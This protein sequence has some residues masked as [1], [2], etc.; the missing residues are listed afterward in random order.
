MSKYISK[1]RYPKIRKYRCKSRRQNGGSSCGLSNPV[2]LPQ[3]LNGIKSDYPNTGPSVQTTGT[4]FSS[5]S[6]QRGG[7]CG[8]GGVMMGGTKNYK[9]GICP[10]MSGLLGGRSHKKNC[11]CMYCLAKKI[12]SKSK[13]SKSMR[14]KSRRYKLKQMN[15][16][17]YNNLFGI[18]TDTKSWSPNNPGLVSN[19]LALNNYNN[20]VQLQMKALG[21]NPP[22][23]SGGTYANSFLQDAQN[24]F[25]QLQYNSGASYNALAGY[26]QPVN[27]LPY[28]DQLTHSNLAKIY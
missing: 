11:K 19:H 28:K 22:F 21:G 20:D 6:P 18:G 1:K 2:Q 26:P 25:R 10:C 27:P 17:T 4:I 23:Q 16:G 13:R 3:N 24:A 12:K 9:G 7:S 8:C 5:S 15:G 14:S